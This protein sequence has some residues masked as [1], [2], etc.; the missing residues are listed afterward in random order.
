[1]AGIVHY[2]SPLFF[3]FTDHDGI[4]IQRRFL[5]TQRRVET[6]ENNTYASASILGRN[7]IR[8]TRGVCLDTD[9][10]YIRLLVKW[11]FLEPIIVKPDVDIARRQSG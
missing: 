6:A 1:M 5:R 2:R 3:C 11:N 8:A 9:R 4:G 7:L 10:N